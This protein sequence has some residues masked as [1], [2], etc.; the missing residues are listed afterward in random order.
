MTP[1]EA[2]PAASAAGDRLLLAVARQNRGPTALLVVANLTR[3]GVA[4][5]VPAVTAAAV[6]GYG[7]GRSAGPL[8]WALVALAAAGVAAETVAIGYGGAVVARTAATL[9]RRLAGAVFDLGPTGGHRFAPG[10][11]SA[12]LAT[13]AGHAAAVVPVTLS[14]VVTLVTAVAGIVAIGWYDVRLALLVVLAIPTLLLLMRTL[15]VRFSRLFGDYQRIQGTIAARLT[16]ALGG[17]RTIRAAGTVDREIGRV[18]APLPE[19]RDAGLA[20]WAQQR[21]A[22]W[23]IGLLLPLAEVAVLAAAGVAVAAGRLPAAGM[24]AV[25]GYLALVLGALAQV[26]SVMLL[27][28]ARAAAAR[29]AEVLDTAPAPRTGATAPPAGGGEVRLRG[30]R[31]GPA[32]APV[33]TGVDLCLPAGSVV[34]VVGANGAG[35]SAL[36]ALL[37]R[38]AEPDAGQ[39]L[40]DGVATTALAD[41]TLRDLVGYAF[42]EPARLGDTVRSMIGYGVPGELSL[43]D[44][45]AAAKLAGADEFVRRLPAGYE[46]GWTDAP[47]SGGELQRLGLAQAFARRTRVLVLD[48]A[49]SSLDTATEARIGRALTARAGGGTRIIVTHRPGTAAAA[50][51]VVWL[52]GA[53]VRATGRHADLWAEPDYRSVFGAQP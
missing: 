48:D 39:V 28:Q 52:D 35:K 16:D 44:A 41:R 45:V 38:L 33:L 7:A 3:A 42:E 47:L 18:L 40:I 15:L 34:A 50:G 11:L 12:R 46:T 24:L 17:V 13:G 51:T 53:T 32:A 8:L 10:D 1:I 6:T 29:L 14:V 25:A 43:A 30:V 36:A 2:A 19:L 49:T 20:A 37:G 22:V 9:R 27:A 4:L 23:R 21:R 31:I 26:D 5:S